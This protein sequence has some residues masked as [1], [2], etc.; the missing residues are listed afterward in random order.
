MN[1]VQLANKTNE[2]ATKDSAV[3][4]RGAKPKSNL[5]TRTTVN[6]WLD[7][8]LLI[9]FLGL[10][11]CSVVVRFVFPP[12]ESVKGWTLWGRTYDWWI[13]LQFGLISALTFGILIHVMLHWNWV[14]GVITSWLGRRR[15]G[16]VQWDDG[17]KTLYGVGLIIVICNI[18]GLGIAAA[19]L[20]IH[21]PF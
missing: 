21:E 8:L 20:S 19:V 18:V 12:V 6:F 4:A 15:G 3:A 5:M 9:V 16:K 10:M 14:C 1:A 17:Y 13:S 2:P 11:W 7:T